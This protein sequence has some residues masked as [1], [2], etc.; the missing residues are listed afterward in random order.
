MNVNDPR[1]KNP[2][3]K[4]PPYEQPLTGIMPIPKI[5][6]QIW[7]GP[8]KP[9]KKWMQTW[10]DLNPDWEYRLW[11]ND[12][13]KKTRW[14]NQHIIDEYIRRYEED[15]KYRANGLDKFT[16]ARGAT[17]IGEKA[18]LFAWHVIADLMRYEILY[19]HGGYMPG[20][21]SECIRPINAKFDGQDFGVYTVRTGNLYVKQRQNLE[22]KYPDGNPKG[23]DILKW[24]RYAYENASPILACKP[25]NSFVKKLVDELHQLKPEDLGEAVDTT[26]NVFM[27]K[28]IRKYNPRNIK[29][30][31]YVVKADKVKKGD[32]S[33]HYAGTTRN[34]YNLGR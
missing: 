16:S 19:R 29:M 32:Y 33:I 17:F 31:D 13:L 7:V 30:V 14:H 27:G 15:V 20:S 22:Q 25:R 18:T 26:G 11:D 3:R 4:Y 10:I 28:M 34:R 6:H 1:F 2:F 24:D 5:I 12:K 21:D 8:L 9:P 23:E